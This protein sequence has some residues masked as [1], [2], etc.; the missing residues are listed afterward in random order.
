[1]VLTR[2]NTSRWQKFDSSSQNELA[3]SHN[4]C[5]RSFSLP[6]SRPLRRLRYI[7]FHFGSLNVLL[8]LFFPF[9][10]TLHI[11]KIIDGS[12]T[13]VFFVRCE[14]R[15]SVWQWCHASLLPKTQVLHN[16]SVSFSV[17]F[18]LWAIGWVRYDRNKNSRCNQFCS[19]NTRSSSISAYCHKRQVVG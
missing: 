12:L 14:M 6:T 15:W 5:S 16:G 19:V 11:R 2:F 4:C 8:A 18:S 7:V 17:D 13:F 3:M 10:T 9:F 1:M